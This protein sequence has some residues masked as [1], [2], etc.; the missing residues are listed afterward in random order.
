MA[1]NNFY[2]RFRFFVVLFLLLLLIF[3]MLFLYIYICSYFSSSLLYSGCFFLLLRAELFYSIFFS[4]FLHILLK[5]CSPIQT[6][7]IV[8]EPCKYVVYLHTHFQRCNSI[9]GLFLAFYPFI[10]WPEVWT[11]LLVYCCERY[12]ICVCE[13]RNILCDCVKFVPYTSVH[14]NAHKMRRTFDWQSFH[15]VVGWLAVLFVYIYIYI[16]IAF[17]NMQTGMM[18]KVKQ[19]IF[20]S[21]HKSDRKTTTT[22]TAVY[23]YLIYTVIFCHFPL[24][25]FENYY[26]L[27]CSFYFFSFFFSFCEWV[28]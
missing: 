18:L 27:A 17:N 12:F 13:A 9:S 25:F 7:W 3:M 2:A 8:Y 1:T 24:F 15:F 28:L 19:K 26:Y 10:S 21:P 4:G 23:R 5:R 16:C 11:R 20:K 14:Q 6:H 22:T